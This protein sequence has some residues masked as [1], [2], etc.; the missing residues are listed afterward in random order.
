MASDITTIA[1]LYTEVTRLLDGEDPT[2][3][4]ISVESLNRLLRIAQR[5]IYRDMRTRFNEVA[6]SALTTT[7][8]AATLPS[9]FEAVSEIH[10][11]KQ[12][13][14]PVTRQ[15]LRAM[16][17][18]GGTGDA[19]YF[20]RVDGTL[21]FWPEV[22]NGTTVQGSYWARLADLTDANLASNALFQAADDLFIFA[23][24]VESGPF[25]DSIQ[26]MPIWEAKY[27][28]IRDALNTDD[29]RAAYSAGRARVRPST[30]ILR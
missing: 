2:V 12:P 20:A 15:V 1:S 22:S 16:V 13:L 29:M 11:G 26:R 4:D 19:C 9:D 18:D 24:L 14:Q 27:A 23:C 10:F 25:F 21:K 17:D 28:S 30:R 5:R 6:F 3:A 8:N 7:S